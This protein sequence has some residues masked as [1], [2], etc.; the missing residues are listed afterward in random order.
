MLAPYGVVAGI[1]AFNWP[2]IHT[3]GRQHGGIETRRSGATDHDA[4]R[5]IAAASAAYRSRQRTDNWK[6][7]AAHPPIRKYPFLAF[8]DTDIDK[9][10]AVAGGRIFQPG[11]S[12]HGGIASASAPFHPWGIRA[13]PLRR[14]KATKGRWRYEIVW[15]A[16]LSGMSVAWRS[17][18]CQA[19]QVASPD[20]DKSSQTVPNK[21]NAKRR[22]DRLIRDIQAH[23]GRTPC[24][25]D[26]AIKIGSIRRRVFLLPPHQTDGF[27]LGGLIGR[28]ILKQSKR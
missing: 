27:G 14:G 25:S 10:L 5:Q 2:P 9:A 23:R 26:L 8:G 6:A 24:Y 18:G 4:H 17:H 3:G 12:L 15:S 19:S 1:I 11:R 13:P 28:H 20:A 22:H 21:Y 7:L 16:G